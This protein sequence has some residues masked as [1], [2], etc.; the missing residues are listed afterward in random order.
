MISTRPEPADDEIDLGRLFGSLWKGKLWILLG[1]VLGL[2]GALFNRVTFRPTI[3]TI[4]AK[5]G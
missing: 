1:M 3:P 2:S 4:C 5:R